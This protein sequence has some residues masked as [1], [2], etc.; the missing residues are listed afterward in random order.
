MD[1][2]PAAQFRQ[3][4]ECITCGAKDFTTLSSGNYKDDPLDT[5]LAND[6][7]GVDP[8]PFLRDA[9]WE[10]V[11]CQACGQKF[12]RNILNDEWIGIY[13]SEWI[14]SESLEIFR[15]RK[16]SSSF[17]QNHKKGIHAT[18]R[19][20]LIEKMS[21]GI[22][23]SDPVRVLDF[24]CGEGIFLSVCAG[25]GFEG[26][27]VEFSEARK[28]EQRIDFYADLDG[29]E[30]AV[31]K[32]H[33]HAVTLFE[34]LEHLADPLPTL[35]RLNPL[36]KKGGVLMLETPNCADVTDMT[37]VREYRLINPLGHVNGF[38]PESQ[39]KIAKAAGFSRVNTSVVQ[40]SAEM[41]RVYKREAKR[42][43]KPFLKR[44]TQQVFIKD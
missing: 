33:F 37:N 11:Q 43:L 40:C 13:Y 30:A 18:E 15:S 26:V 22:R 7:F 23:G 6:P 19:A 3:R 25:L 38:S 31:P 10:F 24:G 29:V 35:K 2:V 42:F 27:G 12:H 28:A 20:L 36:L 8:R 32:E 14:T 21:R 39:E 44:F 41:K 9:K 34:V 5:Y 16:G 1:A 17:A 4:T